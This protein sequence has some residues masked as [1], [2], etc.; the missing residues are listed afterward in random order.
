MWCCWPRSNPEK[1]TSVLP[2]EAVLKS[3][4]KP[5]ELKVDIDDDRGK[6]IDVYD[7]DTFTLAFYS[8]GQLFR[9]KIRMLGIDTPEIRGKTEQERMKACVARDALSDLILN[10]IVDLKNMKMEVKWGRLLADV[11]CGETHVNMFMLQE[12][13]AV[14][15][16]G[17]YG[18]KKTHAW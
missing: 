8:K 14:P 16:G 5:Y 2:L 9:T 7:G 6:V 3:D 12:D 17:A 10:K 18:L 13:Y 15:Y 4:T 1:E 11:W